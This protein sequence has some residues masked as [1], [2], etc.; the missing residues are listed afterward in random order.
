MPAAI[1]GK[2]QG[3]GRAQNK[4][5][6]GKQARRL[7]L[8]LGRLVS[9]GLCLLLGGS[10]GRG[11]LVLGRIGSRRRGRSGALGLGVVGGRPQGEVVAEQL[12]D[13][14]AVLVGVL[15]ESVEFGDRVIEGLKIFF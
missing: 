11:S 2:L 9:L 7:G 6:R 10:S 13:K 15:V 5:E 12:H 3:S 1:R 8:G 14:G 4:S